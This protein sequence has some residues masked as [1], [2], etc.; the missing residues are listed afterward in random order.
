MEKAGDI[1]K[2]FLQERNLGAAL[3]AHGLF[4]SWEALVGS[5]LCRHTRVVDIVGKKLII[6]A[7]HPGWF[8][9]LGL[10]RKEITSKLRKRYPG[11]QIDGIRMKLAP[12]ETAGSTGPPAAG[13]ERVAER[14]S[15]EEE[16]DERKAKGNAAA[17]AGRES[18]GKAG[19]AEG[20]GV[21]KI[22]D[23]RLRRG[24]ERLHDGLMKKDAE[25][26]RQVDR[27]G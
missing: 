27:G 21:E 24:L 4:D 10:R 22:G 15:R 25:D 20:T 7:D 12:R 9:M 13:R 3:E 26:R 23:E 1:L 5:P 18:G 8:Q 17:A 2:S 6:Q 16:P 14:A 19:S 11:L